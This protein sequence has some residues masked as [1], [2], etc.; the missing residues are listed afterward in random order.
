VQFVFSSSGIHRNVSMRL[1]FPEILSV[2]RSSCAG[3]G[4]VVAVFIVVFFLATPVVAVFFFNSPPPFLT[5][6]ICL[7]VDDISSSPHGIKI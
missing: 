4:V 3:A 6:V 2:S 7:F 1:L 5:A